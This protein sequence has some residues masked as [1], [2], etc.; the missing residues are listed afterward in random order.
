MKDGILIAALGIGICTAII[1]LTSIAENQ[2]WVNTHKQIQT[3][4]TITIINGK[5]DTTYTYKLK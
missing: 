2:R 3:D 5:S 4:T 1:F